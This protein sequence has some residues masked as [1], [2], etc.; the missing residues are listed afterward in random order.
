MISDFQ[1]S[2]ITWIFSCNKSAKREKIQQVFARYVVI[3]F[4]FEHGNK[5]SSVYGP[6]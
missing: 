3:F 2:P 6:W 1:E 5:K 4:Y